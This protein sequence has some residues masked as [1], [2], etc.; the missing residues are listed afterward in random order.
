[1]VIEILP[2]HP[3]NQDAVQDLI[4][5]GLVEHWGFLDETKNPD[6][7][8]IAESYKNGTFLVAWLEGEIVGTGAFV[9]Q[10]DETVEVV[11]MSVA[12]HVRRQGIG[13]KVLS[14]LCRQAHQ[15]GYQRVI[16]ETTDTWQNTISFYK[17]FGFKITHYTGGD[18]FF[19][20]DLQVNLGDDG[21]K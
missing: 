16:L 20:F 7:K 1:M 12:R 2:F 9:P 5:A 18:V 8:N 21:T 17:A 19:A 13:R 4:L 3:A 6:L 11:R 10:S 14:E 15:Q